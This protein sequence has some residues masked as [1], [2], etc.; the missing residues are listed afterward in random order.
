VGDNMQRQSIQSSDLRS[1]GY[2]SANQTLEI[3]FNSNGIYQYYGVPASVYQGL[4]G[5]ASHGQYFHA[6]IKD[7]Y[8][9][10]KVS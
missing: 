4:M 9:Y 10:S 7:I 2:D 8:R 6:H 3:E 1:V 5:A